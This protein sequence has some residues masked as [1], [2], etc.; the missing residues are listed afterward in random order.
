MEP[1]MLIVDSQVHI[2]DKGTPSRFHRQAPYSAAQLLADMDEGG[3]DRAVICPPM[4]DPDSNEM[5]VAAARA[6]PGRLAVMGWIHVEQPESRSLVARWK[7][8]PGMLG[9]RLY[10][11]KPHEQSWPTDGTMD[12]L[13]PA[14]ERAGVPIA[15]KAESFLPALG[16]IA[17][18]HPGLKLAVDHMAVPSGGRGAA[19]YRHHPEL[20]DLAR[21]PNIAVKVTG[22]PAYAVDEYPFRST[23]VYL[24]RTFDAFGPERMF[25]GTDITKIP[26][27]WRQCVTMFTEE[28]PWLRGRD[29]ERVMGRAFCD[30]AGW[31]L[32]RD[33][34]GG[35][36]GMSPAG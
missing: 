10:F 34:A 2:W 29:L 9:L 30:W 36:R 22:Q 35:G 16:R 1:P 17:E 4:W 8:R 12:W 31:D 24:Q 26:C 5:A 25:W 15:M 27:P 20:L 14:A 28:L 7:E 3:V 11:Q 33:A 6:H 23:H 32:P 18:R 21:Y 19:A 13:W